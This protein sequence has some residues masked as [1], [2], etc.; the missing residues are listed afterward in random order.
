MVSEGQQYFSQE[1]TG[2]LA[3]KIKS[4]G[5]ETMLLTLK[6]KDVLKLVCK[7]FSSMEISKTLFLSTRTVEGYRARLLEKTGQS[8]TINL[9]LYALQQ[10]LVSLE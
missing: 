4:D 10:N 7:G 3:K 9:V 6:E 2:K 1:I 8:N 5:S